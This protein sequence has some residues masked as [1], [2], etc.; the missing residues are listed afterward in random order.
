MKEVVEGIMQEI[1]SI[2]KKKVFLSV[3]DVSEILGCT[4]EEVHNLSRLRKHQK[5]PPRIIV[6]KEVRY[7]KKAFVEWL[8][9]ERGLQGLET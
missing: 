4:E 1:N 2:Y 7:P 6:F 3:Q 9:M 5:K 8:L